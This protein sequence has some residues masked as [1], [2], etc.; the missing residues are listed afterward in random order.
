MR[1]ALVRWASS[2]YLRLEQNYYEEIDKPCWLFHS[3][4]TSTKILSSHL[5]IINISAK[6]KVFINL[7]QQI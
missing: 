2:S 5:P 1:E 7:P 6:Y 3:F 4:K